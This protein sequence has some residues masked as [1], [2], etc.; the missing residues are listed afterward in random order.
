MR[1]YQFPAV[2]IGAIAMFIVMVYGLWVTALAA[3]PVC[4]ENWVNMKIIDV[5]FN[6][7]TCTRYKCT[8]PSYYYTLEGGYTASTYDRRAG[9]ITINIGQSPEKDRCR[10]G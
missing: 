5:Q 8:E 2:A 6:P 9:E 10:R 3:I 1:S 4:N 7:V